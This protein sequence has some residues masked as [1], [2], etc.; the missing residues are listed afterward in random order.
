MTGVSYLMPH[1][2]TKILLARPY[3]AVSLLRALRTVR[4]AQTY[5]MN[6]DEVPVTSCIYN[7]F[8]FF[9]FFQ[10]SSFPSPSARW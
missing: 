10:A 6:T 4:K 5:Y 9:S 8:F 3:I 1:I 7:F 2:F